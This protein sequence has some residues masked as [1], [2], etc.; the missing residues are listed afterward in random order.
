MKNWPLSPSAA[1]E[2]DSGHVGPSRSVT[3]L[4]EANAPLTERFATEPSCSDPIKR[5]TQVMLGFE[6]M[7]SADAVLSGIDD[8]QIAGEVCL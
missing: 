5:R 2:T 8:A 6:S 1:T 3:F 7:A 4:A